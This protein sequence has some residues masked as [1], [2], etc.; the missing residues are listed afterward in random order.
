GI[1]LL[2]PPSAETVTATVRFAEYI[3]EPTRVEGRRR[4][5]DYWR[6]KPKQTITVEVPL[7]P[8]SLERGIPL[9]NTVGLVLTGR[10]Q[11]VEN[12]HGVPAGTRA[13][14]LFLVNRRTPGEKGRRDEQFIF[15][16]EL[17]VEC[18]QGIVPRPNAGGEDSD[19]WD[20]RVADLQFRDRCEYAVGHNV[21]VEIP[22]GQERV[23]RARTTWLPF[24]EVRRV[25]AHDEPGV[26][27][28]MED[29]ARL[30][31]GNEVRVRLSRLPQ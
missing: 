1:S 11:D 26:T 30:A 31:D 5:V 29:L 18:A 24:H 6:R 23:T 8:E 27:V 3:V 10:I 16:V 15:Q 28:A 7:R 2:V 19:H 4:P 25:V 17:A 9:P 13:L 12:A 21:A 14:A 22:P 20:E